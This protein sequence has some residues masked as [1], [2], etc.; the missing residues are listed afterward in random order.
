MNANTISKRP[1]D[2]QVLRLMIDLISGNE[3]SK[4]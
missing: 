2:E 4:K 3:T 1:V